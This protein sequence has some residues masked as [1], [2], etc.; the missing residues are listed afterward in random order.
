MTTDLDKL[1]A[2]Y[3]ADTSHENENALVG[4]ITR[5]A[6]RLAVRY[7]ATD[8][9]DIAQDATIKIWAAIA[10]YTP[11]TTFRA[12]A[13]TIT[14]NHIR[15]QA[16]AISRRPDLHY[17]DEPPEPNADV[18]ATTE[19]SLARFNDDERVLLHT[20]AQYLDFGIT[21]AKLGITTKAL[22]SRLERIKNKYGHRENNSISDVLN[23]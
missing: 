19:Y 10:T 8:A 12:W 22:R 3:K 1:Y 7:G 14:L 23:Q 21:A 18:P 6:R 13:A 9:D 15:D 2:L 16:R 20:F 5:Y 4:E 17:S 11:A